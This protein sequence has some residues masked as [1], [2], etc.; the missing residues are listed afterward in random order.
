MRRLDNY[1]ISNPEWWHWEGYNRVLNDDAP[2]EARKSYEHY[3]E[4]KKVNKE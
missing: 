1:W 2:E 4:Q 3:L